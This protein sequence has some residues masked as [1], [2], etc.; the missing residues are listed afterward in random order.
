[1][2]TVVSIYQEPKDAVLHLSR[3]ERSQLATRLLDSLDDDDN[4]EIS[5]EWREELR[6]RVHDIDEGLT[7]PVD[8]EEVWKLVNEQFGTNFPT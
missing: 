6:R 3:P 2:A 1:M 5:P 4:F 7:K 8:K